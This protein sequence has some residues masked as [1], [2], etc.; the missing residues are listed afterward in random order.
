[1]F[2]FLLS[3]TNSHNLTLILPPFDRDRTRNA[4]C[5]RCHQPIDH[6]ITPD[7]YTYR[8]CSPTATITGATLSNASTSVACRLEATAFI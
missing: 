5:A 6:T 2:M 3:H 4:P 7:E 1:M 8:S